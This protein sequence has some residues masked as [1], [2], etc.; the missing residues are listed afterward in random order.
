MNVVVGITGGIAAYKAVGVVRALVL[1]GHDVHVVATEAALRFVGKPTLE[2]ISRNAVHTELYEGVAEVRHVAIGQAADL[3]VIAP[4]TAHT[5]AKLATGL[6]DD[7]LGNT[8][9]ASTAPLVVAPAMHT[10]MWANPATV[11]NVE[12]LRSRGV[13][14]VG[15]ASG[16][17]TGSDSGPGRMEEPATIVAEALAVHR[18]AVGAKRDLEGLR[19]LVTAGGTREP[20]DPVRFV[21]NRSSGRQGVALALAAAARGASVTVLAAN[22]DVEAPRGV[23]V[24]AV[25]TALELREAALA[26]AADADIVIMAAA[27]ADYRPADVSESKIKKEQQGDR[28]VLELVKNPDILAE[29]AAAK[30]GNQLVVGFAAETEPDREAMLALGRAKIARK[31]CDLLVLN[32]VGWTEGFQSESNAVVVLDRA[33]DIV[34]EASGTKASVADRVLDVVAR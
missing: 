6:A 18:R 21:G 16:Q 3:I 14:V 27:V 34:I 28:L 4:A 22:L 13:H 24:V 2:A 31:G 8:V 15:P 29:I 12:T 23:E 9:L 5:L 25:G 33:G 32:R 20:M 17:L 7:L 1:E 19:V 11:A 26:A 30:A 10:E